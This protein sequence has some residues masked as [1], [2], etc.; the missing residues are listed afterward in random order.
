MKLFSEQNIFLAC[1]SPS[2]LS[3]IKVARASYQTLSKS[4]QI[5]Q[6]YSGGIVKH[7]LI[8]LTLIGL[9]VVTLQGTPATAQ[10]NAASKQGQQQHLCCIGIFPDRHLGG[11]RLDDALRRHQ[12]DSFRRTV[13]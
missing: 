9:A 11:R 8:A 13:D 1:V 12:V 3:G 5:Q 4:C 2:T 7:T 10:T 6:N